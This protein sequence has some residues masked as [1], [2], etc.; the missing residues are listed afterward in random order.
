MQWWAN[1]EHEIP[2]IALSVLCLFASM[3]WL[4]RRQTRWLALAVASYFASLLFYAEA[5]L[6]PLFVVGLAYLVPSR[7][8]RSV[9]LRR[10]REDLPLVAALIIVTIAYVGAVE[11][12]SYL[13][14]PKRAGAATSVRT[15]APIG[16]RDS[17]PG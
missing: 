10:L 6:T 14:V 16:C 9:S 12:G 13:T 8:S 2:W 17:V 1:A 15:S 11:A 7:A 5:V 3:R 4:A